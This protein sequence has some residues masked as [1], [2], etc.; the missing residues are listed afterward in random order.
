M[1]H[2]LTQDTC[3][4]NRPVIGSSWFIPLLEY[5]RDIGWVPDKWYS[6]G[7]KGTLMIGASSTL[8]SWRMTG[9]ILSGPA[10]FLGIR[11][12]RRFNIPASEILMSGIRGVEFLRS[13]GKSP[14]LMTLSSTR[15]STF[16]RESSCNE[17][18][19]KGVNTDWYCWFSMFAFS[20]VSVSRFPFCF[21]GGMPCWSVWEFLLTWKSFLIFPWPVALS[22]CP[23]TPSSPS[24][25]ASWLSLVFFLIVCL[26]E[27]YFS[28]SWELPVFL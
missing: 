5:R 26:G 14:G 13:S 10:A 1:F 9:L 4:G 12:F 22:F 25:Y 6:T 23:S 3:K 16:M 28:L 24:R 18:G 11:F 19:A 21:R 7:L 15:S 8:S 17:S 27:T 2:D 20:L